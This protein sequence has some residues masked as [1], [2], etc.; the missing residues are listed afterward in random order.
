MVA[1]SAGVPVIP[2]LEGAETGGC[3][4]C[5]IS[6]GY[7]VRFSLVLYTE[8]EQVFKKETNTNDFIS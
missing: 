2:G 4:K 6:G 1:R 5:K 7:T 8:W 3:W